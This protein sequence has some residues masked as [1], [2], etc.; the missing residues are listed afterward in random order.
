MRYQEEF[1]KF[2]AEH[3]THDTLELAVSPDKD[4]ELGN[5]KEEEARLAELIMRA[6]QDD[7]EA[8]AEIYDQYATP[9]YRYIAFRVPTEVAEDLMSDVFVKAWEK[10]HLYKVRRGIPFSSWLFRIARNSVIDS[11]RTFRETQELDELHEDENRWNDPK[12]TITHQF[13][14]TLL[15]QAIRRLPKRHQEVLS[16]SYFSGLSHLEISRSLRIREG[17]VRIIKHR[18]LKKLQDMLPASMREELP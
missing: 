6:Q 13:Q 11:Y 16:L 10:L 9:I 1:R 17:S 4:V 2:L 14:T 5:K 7:H 8:F 18:A 15:R 12:L 3:A